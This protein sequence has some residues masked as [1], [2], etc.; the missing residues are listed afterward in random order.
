MREA[1]RFAKEKKVKRLLKS[2][3]LH[4]TGIKQLPCWG[5]HLLHN[6]INRWLFAVR[7]VCRIPGPTF[8]LAWGFWGPSGIYQSEMGGVEGG[9]GWV[10]KLGPESCK[11]KW[12]PVGVVENFPPL[13][14]TFMYLLFKKPSLILINSLNILTGPN[15][16]AHKAMVQQHL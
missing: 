10:R 9:G 4:L 5:L 12:G 1:L 15:M 16:M 6:P 7:E 8:L 3:K 13:S 14:L 2:L 11:R